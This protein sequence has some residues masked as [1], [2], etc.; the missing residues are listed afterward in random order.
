MDHHGSAIAI[1]SDISAQ[2]GFSMSAAITPPYGVLAELTHRCPL[3]CL[4]C[5]NPVE[6]KE[7]ESELT[8]SQWL[9]AISSARDLGAV[10]LHL[11]GGE[12]LLREDLEQ[13]VE[14]A[15][16]RGFYINLITS[17]ATLSRERCDRLARSGIDN[18]QLSIQ[19]D[20][21]ETAEKI[22]GRRTVK[23]KLASAAN[24]VAAGLPLSW[25]IVLHKLNSSRVKEITSLCAEFKPHRIELAHAQFHGLALT[26]RHHLVLSTEQVLQVERDV[27]ELREQYNDVDIVYVRSDWQ[28]DFPKPCNGGWGKLQLTI[29]PDGTVMPCAGAYAI[30]SLTFENLR[31]H[32]LRWI[33]YDSPSFNAF[34]GTDWMLE[35]CRTC[36]E[37]ER[38]F[39]GCRCQAFALTGDAAK[40]DPVCI[41]SPEREKLK[42]QF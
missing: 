41:Y 16:K 35:P 25:N 8:T 18:V 4:Y 27:V 10:Q 36:P 32:D 14:Y 33:W 34:R 5:S 37:R 20:D 9:E 39:G 1:I 24:I 38:D 12:P 6:L 17:G 28:Q 40:V 42:P 7:A 29:A 23:S 30:K 22:C 3:A 11:S 13:I 21:E 26:N 19:A 2:L 31:S 15:S